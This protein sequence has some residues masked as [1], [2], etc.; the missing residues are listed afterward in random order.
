[1][2][3]EVKGKKIG[4]F[5][6]WVSLRS[7]LGDATILAFK[8]PEREKKSAG[9]QG[10]LAEAKVGGQYSKESEGNTWDTIIMT[11]EHGVLPMDTWKSMAGVEKIRRAVTNTSGSIIPV[12]L[13]ERFVADLRTDGFYRCKNC[14]EPI[15]FT[16]ADGACPS[17]GKKFTV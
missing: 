11:K 8:R 16:P 4:D 10:S 7:D 3:D 17:C 9:A 12:T 2:N 5:A 13:G 6:C 1:M 14:G 15:V